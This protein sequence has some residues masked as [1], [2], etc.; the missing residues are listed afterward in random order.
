MDQAFYRRDI[1]VDKI[2]WYMHDMLPKKYSA[3]QPCE[4]KRE[5]LDKEQLKKEIVLAGSSAYEAL[6]DAT[7]KTEL[8]EL[9]H[10]LTD[11]KV[12][13]LYRYVWIWSEDNSVMR[14]GKSW[15]TSK[16]ECKQEGKRNW[17]S[18]TT[19]DGPGSP[20]AQLSVEAICPCFVHNA[21]NMHELITLPCLCF[22]PTIPEHFKDQT[23]LKI[24][25]LTIVKTPVTNFSSCP[26]YEYIVKETGKVFSS[27]E[28]DT[29]LA[30]LERRR[31]C[32]VSSHAN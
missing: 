21:D 25:G 10:H 5:P 32:I 2:A 3:D 30:Y 8:P 17:P 28:K 20:G 24:D 7:E 6:I 31:Y 12:K 18:Y 26:K 29:Y 14:R 4:Q 22:T 19:F 16:E 11:H 15:F 9:I 13:Q 1:P 23:D 27:H